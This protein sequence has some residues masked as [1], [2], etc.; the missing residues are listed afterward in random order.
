MADYPLACIF[1][2]DGTVVD[3]MSFHNR[4][5]V[6]L[7][8]HHNHHVEEDAFYRATA[9]MVNAAIFRLYFGD[10]ISDD[11]IN[12]LS[13]EKESTYRS[14]YRDHRQPVS[15]LIHFL[16]ECQNRSIPCALSTSAPID[17]VQFIMEGTGLQPYFQAIVTGAD[18]THS[19]PH[20]EIF[21]KTAEKL[22][23]E[24]KDCIA[25]EDAPMGIESAHRAGMPVVVI[26]TVLPAQDALALPGV[27][28]AVP[29]FQAISLQSLSAF[30]P[31]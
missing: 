15:G 18:V 1:D 16:T 14:V 8:R 13:H 29:D 3:N 24:P 6:E 20:P 17:N 7:L 10:N 22:G 31:A 19:K 23:V 4:T 28:Q 27:V 11:Q 21:L 2:M 5:W 26:T 25:F 30:Q 9:G 12:A